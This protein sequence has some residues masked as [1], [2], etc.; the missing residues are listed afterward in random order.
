MYA[1]IL[2][3]AGSGLDPAITNII[4][5]GGI[6]LIFY[7]FMIRPQQQKQKAQRKFI[8]AIRKGD[9][10]VT[11]GGIHGKIVAIEENNVV[12]EVD[13]GA[14]VK[15]EKSAISLESSKQYAATAKETT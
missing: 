11:I 12:L 3:Q 1:L 15:F 4:L 2:L 9:M 10:V 7:F 6:A 8:D 14:R 13:R 5:F